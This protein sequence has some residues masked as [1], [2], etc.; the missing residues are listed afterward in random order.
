MTALFTIA[1]TWK[2]LKWPSI[3]ERIEK[4]KCIHTMEY[5][6]A[7]KQSEITSFAATWTDSDIIKLK[8]SKSE[9]ERRILHNITYMWNRNDT[10]E[11]VHRT[12][13]RQNR[14][15][16]AEGQGRDG[17]GFGVSRCNHSRTEC[18]NNK[19]LLYST[20]TIFNIRNK[21]QEKGTWKEYIHMYNWIT[22]LY[23]RNTTL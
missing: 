8:W 16:V 9:L 20:G 22:L 23:S 17:T 12:D 19:L 14:P 6:T 21:P 4:M 10:N 3:N 5:Y 11:P 7:I 2:Q 18:V 1:K 15:V 13:S